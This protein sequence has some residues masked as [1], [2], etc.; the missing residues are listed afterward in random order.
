[1]PRG[2]YIHHELIYAP[3]ERH[4]PGGPTSVVFLGIGPECQN[5]EVES[6]AAMSQDE[7]DQSWAGIEP[8]NDLSVSPKNIS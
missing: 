8:E 5:K 4:G 7:R 3:L 1:M 6:L 2:Q